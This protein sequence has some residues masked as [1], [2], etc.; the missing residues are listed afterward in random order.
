MF[1]NFYIDIEEIRD[2]VEDH[3]P[4]LD[5]DFFFAVLNLILPM[6]LG[7]LLAAMSFVY[8]PSVAGIETVAIKTEELEPDL[9]MNAYC[10]IEKRLPGLVEFGEYIAYEK[11][12]V[13][14]VRPVVDS[15]EELGTFEVA[16]PENGL[17]THIEADEYLGVIFFTI[18][19][20]GMIV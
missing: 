9:P 16:N 3:T 6:V 11:D 15:D 2:W 12:G 18:P 7:V 5:A 14:C 8:L 20:L 1:D 17:V 4:V 19:Y 13:R 10:Y